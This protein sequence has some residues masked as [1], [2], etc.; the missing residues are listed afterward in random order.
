MFKIL[1]RSI[2]TAPRKSREI[3][4]IDVKYKAN[5]RGLSTDEY[6]MFVKSIRPPTN[7]TIAIRRFDFRITANISFIIIILGND[8]IKIKYEFNFSKVT[9]YFIGSVFIMVVS[10]DT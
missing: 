7:I 8:G 5:N 3:T 2:P 6:S 9:P 10:V 4:N 1:F